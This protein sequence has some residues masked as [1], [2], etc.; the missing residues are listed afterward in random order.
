[1]QNFITITLVIVCPILG[2]L[3]VWKVFDHFV[4][5]DSAVRMNNFMYLLKRFLWSLGVG[6]VALGFGLFILFINGLAMIG[7]LNLD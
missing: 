4:S 1:M 7:L 2:F 6:A 5:L 3:F